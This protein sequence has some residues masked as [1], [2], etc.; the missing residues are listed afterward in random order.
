MIRKEPIPV[1]NK[2]SAPIKIAITD[3]SPIDPGIIPKKEL[4]KLY[5]P[6][7]RNSL[8]LFITYNKGKD[9]SES[10]N[11]PSNEQQQQRRRTH[12]LGYRVCVSCMYRIQPT[13]CDH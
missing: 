11:T 1:N 9:W 4:D 7:P 5:K 13:F 2:I 8:D 10:T 12:T 6:S 3:V